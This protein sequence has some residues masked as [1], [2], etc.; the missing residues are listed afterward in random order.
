MT[1]VGNGRKRM[2]QPERSAVTRQ[3]LIDA[4]IECL[5]ELGYDRTTITE[6]SER[7][8]LSHGAHLHHF[9][10]RPALLAAAAIELAQRAGLDLAASVAGLPKGR[11]RYAA[12]VDMLWDLF[13]G[14]L[15]QA[16][17]ELGVHA[18]TD[19][20]LRDQLDPL[21]L[22]IGRM[23]LPLL[24]E[25]FGREQ[26]DSSIDDLIAMVTATIRGVAIMAVLDPAHH[27][28]KR[29]QRSRRM[30]INVLDTQL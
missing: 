6:I 30:L 22:A 9:G 8:G 20:E 23:T 2:T 19:P 12:S 11:K 16:V 14:P 4:T 26:E 1:A 17:L 13:T 28:L 7:A 3:A 21:E 25:A 5:A 15:F 24:R 10:T 29:W 27:P 18:R